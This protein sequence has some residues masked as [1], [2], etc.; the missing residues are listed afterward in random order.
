MNSSELMARVKAA[1]DT[2]KRLLT[3]TPEREQ[4]RRQLE[5]LEGIKAD[6]DRGL[7]DLERRFTQLEER[8]RSC[9]TEFEEAKAAG[10]IGKAKTL[11]VRAEEWTREH[12]SLEQEIDFHVSQLRLVNESI[13]ALRAKSMSTAQP[14]IDVDDLIIGKQEAID[15]AAAQ[16]ASAEE[17][18]SLRPASLP[19]SQESSPKR[20]VDS[21]ADLELSPDVAAFARPKPVT[22]AKSPNPSIPDQT[23]D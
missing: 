6:A 20:L 1:I 11:K 15:R 8:I 7:R 23:L 21:A 10:Q 9:I 5:Q 14:A 13:S 17:L 4:V 12:K 19:V 16:L 22:P 2:G 3:G 18:G